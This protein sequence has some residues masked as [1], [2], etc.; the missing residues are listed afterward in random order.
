MTAILVPA[1]VRPRADATAWLEAAFL[2]TGLGAIVVVRWA[3][4]RAGLDALGVG[5]AFGLALGTLVGAA[6]IGG[7]I[8]RAALRGTAGSSLVP[9]I[10]GSAF[11][12]ALVGV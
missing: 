10:I 9:A 4:T 1:R 7:G 6:G 3:A 8:R 11:G 12:L 5:L 2:A